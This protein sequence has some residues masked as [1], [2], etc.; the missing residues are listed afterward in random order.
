MAISTKNNKSI[1]IGEEYCTVTTFVKGFYALEDQTVNHCRDSFIDA[2]FWAMDEGYALYSEESGASHYRE[3]RDKYVSSNGEKAKY[4]PRLLNYITKSGPV[5]VMI[6]AMS[7][8]KA[9]EVAPKFGIEVNPDMSFE[10]NMQL[11]Y[12]VARAVTKKCRSEVMAGYEEGTSITKIQFA[13]PVEDK[14]TMNVIHCSDGYIAAKHERN[15]AI[16]AMNDFEEA[17][18]ENPNII[19]DFRKELMPY[20]FGDNLTK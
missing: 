17:E 12:D 6:F 1:G 14:M 13:D 4:Y 3:H 9:K 20:E 19:E 16:D 18:S 5:Y 10:D 7:L 8:E 11:V 15:I 2:G